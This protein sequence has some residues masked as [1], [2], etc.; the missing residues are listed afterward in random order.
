[1]SL[2][3][4]N[5]DVMILEHMINN[6]FQYYKLKY[7]NSLQKRKEISEALFKL[8]QMKY[9]DNNNQVITTIVNIDSSSYLTFGQRSKDEITNAI[10]GKSTMLTYK[11][12]DNGKSWIRL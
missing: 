3:L 11:S 1:M 10:R 7:V 9:I 6:K 5:Y 12:F 2:Y 4:T 8:R